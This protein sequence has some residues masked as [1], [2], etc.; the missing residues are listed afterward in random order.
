MDKKQVAKGYGYAAFLILLLLARP[1]PVWAAQENPET[2]IY[3]LGE[4]E[5]EAFL[6]FVKEKLGT[7]ELDGED[8][9]REAIEAGEDVSGRIAE[10][11]ETLYE[12]YQQ[13][14]ADS[15]R[16]VIQKQVVEPA[17]EAAKDAVENTAKTFW[18]DLKDS[19]VSFFQNIAAAIRKA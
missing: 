19:V 16:E 7:G 5:L 6:D 15:A 13:K 3:S 9:L 1:V 17:A 14:L 18:Q 12:G 11:F 10:S 4:E 2:S 8:E